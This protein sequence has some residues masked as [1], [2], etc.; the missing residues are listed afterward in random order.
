MSFTF[1][2]IVLSIIY[3]GF[4]FNKKTILYKKDLQNLFEKEKQKKYD[5]ILNEEF[6]YIYD[7]II[8]NA[9]IGKTKLSFSIFCKHYEIDTILNEDKILNANILSEELQ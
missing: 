4:L 1:L 6:K 8:Q 7:N 2:V 3:I 5:N 9:K